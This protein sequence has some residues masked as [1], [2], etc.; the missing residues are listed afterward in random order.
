MCFDSG[1]G[2]VDLHSDAVA[3][4]N[5]DHGLDPLTAEGSTNPIVT[6]S[7]AGDNSAGH[8]VC[9]Q[10]RHVQNLAGSV[11]MPV[12]G[13]GMRLAVSL[14]EGFLTFQNDRDVFVNYWVGPPMRPEAESRRKM[15]TVAES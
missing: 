5:A 2:A 12:A 15:V 3:D 10:E 14:V 13:G 6:R 4:Q 9:V 8:P 7:P 11:S 1:I